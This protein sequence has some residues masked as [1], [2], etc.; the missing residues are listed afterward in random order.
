MHEFK[1]EHIE[2]GKFSDFYRD[3]ILPT[4]EALENQRKVLVRKGA[5]ATILAFSAISCL[6][7]FSLIYL[8]SLALYTVLP[9]LFLAGITTFPLLLVPVRRLSMEIKERLMIAIADFL[10]WTYDSIPDAIDISPF[11]N[12]RLIE[13]RHKHAVF[14]DQFLGTVGA[15]S[16]VSIETHLTIKS[17]KDTRR[18][19]KEKYYKRKAYF[20]GQLIICD[21]P[22]EDFGKTIV[23]RDKG[24]FN[25]KTL[26]GMKRIG[27]VDPVFEK[28]F[29]VYGNDQVG[30]RVILDPDF[31]QRVVDLERALSGKNLRF[32]VQ[33]DK[34]Y[35][36]IETKNQFEAGSILVPLNS[37]ERTQV[38][39]DQIGAI[40][41]V[42][43]YILSES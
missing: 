7:I 35:I 17:N 31:M 19:E 41:N 21:F 29:E 5:M 1:S 28:A 25:N 22:S 39:L 2:F 36:V 40:L 23:I 16:F 43:S 12:L 18:L 33:N 15:A 24:V 37:P 6:G 9:V 10:G 26:D 13:K 42:V 3:E 4:L 27:L 34:L 8:N 11:Y 38:L 20:C 14:E 32:G 30:A